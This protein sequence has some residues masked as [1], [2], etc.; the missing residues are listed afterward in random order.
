VSDLY[1]F[2]VWAEGYATDEDGNLLDSEGN[3]VEP[4]DDDDE[5]EEGDQS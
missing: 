1:E 2:K 3:L 5:T 4:P